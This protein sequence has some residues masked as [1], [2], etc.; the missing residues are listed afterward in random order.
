MFVVSNIVESWQYTKH[1]GFVY[2]PADCL[3]ISFCGNLIFFNPANST[4]ISPNGIYNLNTCSS[5]VSSV[6][7]YTF[8]AVEEVYLVDYYRYLDMIDIRRF[9]VVEGSYV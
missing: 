9:K 8:S 5:C 3:D 4:L 2:K 6:D 7:T 1:D